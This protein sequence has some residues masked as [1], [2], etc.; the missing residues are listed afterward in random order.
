MVVQ[1]LSPFVV[2]VGV[3]GGHECGCGF[4]FISHEFWQVGCDCSF[5]DSFEPANSTFVAL[6]SDFRA[7]RTAPMRRE[8]RRRREEKGRICKKLLTFA[9]KYAS[10]GFIIYASHALLYIIWCVRFSEKHIPR[11]FETPLPRRRERHLPL[12]PFSPKEKCPTFADSF[13]FSSL[14]SWQR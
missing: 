2:V 13:F 6:L 1:W 7:W 11:I 14:P 12:T 4:C 8:R 3:G 5:G 10:L 9:I